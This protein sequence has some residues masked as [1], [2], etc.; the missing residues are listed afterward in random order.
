[1]FK[2]L[3]AP[4]MVSVAFVVFVLRITSYNVCYTKLLRFLAHPVKDR[5]GAKRREVGKGEG[6]AQARRH[7]M[8][9]EHGLDGD[10]A[11]AAKRVVKRGFPAPLHQLEEYGRQ[12]LADRRLAAGGA[13]PATR[14]NFV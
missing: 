11:R 4:F 13:I 8:G 14:N 5:L 10:G 7:V 9:V 3:F 2:K 6:A 1:M 12:G